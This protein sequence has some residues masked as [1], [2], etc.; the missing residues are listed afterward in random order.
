MS[1]KYKETDQQIAACIAHC[2]AYSKI[3]FSFVPDNTCYFF[4]VSDK[5]KKILDDCVSEGCGYDNPQGF[6]A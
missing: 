6:R 4:E 5:D 2:L 1:Y 3:Q